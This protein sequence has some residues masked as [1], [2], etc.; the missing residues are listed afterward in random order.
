M[1]TLAVACGGVQTAGAQA[2]KCKLAFTLKGWSIAY[3]TA[4]G[5]GTITCDNGQSARVT[6]S[7]K[8]GGFT[9]GK[10]TITNGRGE[11]SEVGS[12]DEL[13]GSYATAEAAAGAV[14]SSDAQVLTKGDVSLA[15]SGTGSG[16]DLGISF[17]AFRIT[18][19]K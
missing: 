18:K 9:I 12:I 4:K 13:F 5:S 15:L 7:T 14:R 2:V 10:S 6:L 11:F 3:K 17:G 8:G 19:R 1:L 16:W